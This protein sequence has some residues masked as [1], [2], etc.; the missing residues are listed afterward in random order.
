MFFGDIV[1]ITP[2]DPDDKPP[3]LAATAAPSAECKSSVDVGVRPT[4][5]RTTPLIKAP[6]AMWNGAVIYILNSS[7]RYSK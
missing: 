3:P 1:Y 5:K 7:H 6:P 4:N 2:M